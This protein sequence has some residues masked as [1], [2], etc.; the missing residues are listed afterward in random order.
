MQTG[1]G[2]AAG[3][4]AASR[5][6]SPYRPIPPG[7][8]T[9]LPEERVSA[10]TAPRLDGL[11]ILQIVPEM[12]TGGVERG[13]VDVA[14][15]IVAAG[16]RA[17]VATHGGPMVR[18]L[19]RVGAATHL[20]PVHRKAPWAL[21]RNRGHL[22]RLIGQERVR[23]VHARSRAPAWSALW[24][25]RRAGIPM[26]TTLHAPYNAR[27]ALKRLYN[28]SMAR[29][30]RVIAISRY[31]AAYGQE[32]YGIDPAR[33]TIVPRGIDPERFSLE[34][35]SAER[36]IQ[37]AQAWRLPEDR[38]I[39]LM[40]GRLTRWKGQRVLIE[41]LARLPDPRPLAV[42]VGSDQ[43]R[44]AYRE[45]LD[46]LIAAKGVSSDVLI[47]DHC[48]DMPA[49]YK[50]CDAVVHASTDP[51]GFGR[52]IEE[53][54]AMGR[55]VIASA[56]GAPPEI[57]RDGGE[58]GWLVPPGDPAALADALKTAVTLPAHARTILAARAQAHIR[59]NFTVA[60]MTDAT[61]GVYVAALGG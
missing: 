45:E 48:N 38:P 6:T 58:T 10:L 51:E 2:I 60:A 3:G 4:D 44:L 35:V 30:D 41:A 32:T 17:L 21:W 7:P 8:T 1:A 47:A 40:P 15:A 19:E 50:L 54:G 59:A 53:A 28:S 31:V 23:L 46:R 61:L 18:E 5:L 13:T 22:L 20:L 25:T 29:A 9:P 49:A 57:V 24:A 36:T 33:M 27:S 42:L 37:L 55:P 12:I 39:V 34:A 52:V 16:G 43:G 14:A 26:V 11:T 56:I